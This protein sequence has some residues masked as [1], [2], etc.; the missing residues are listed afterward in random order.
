MAEVGTGRHA[1]G[2][3]HPRTPEDIFKQKMGAAHG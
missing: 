2:V 1:P 3:F